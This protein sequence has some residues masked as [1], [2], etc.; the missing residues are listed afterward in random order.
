MSNTPK[1]AYPGRAELDA[2]NM[3]FRRAVARLNREAK[4]HDPSLLPRLAAIVAEA[5]EHLTRLANDAQTAED[6]SE[7][8][9][10]ALAEAET[11]MQRTLRKAVRQGSPHAARLLARMDDR[12]TAGG[13]PPDD[14]A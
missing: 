12:R 3:H 2:A 6:S 4:R 8:H 14:A 7:R 11:R 5:T 13:A 9:R 1:P 10:K